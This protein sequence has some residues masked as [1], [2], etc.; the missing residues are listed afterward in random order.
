[1]HNFQIDQK[2]LSDLLRKMIAIES[3]NPGLSDQ[4]SG[5]S[6]IAEMLGDYMLTMGLEVE[7]Q[8]PEPGRKNVI[9]IWK[10]I[11]GGKSLLLNGHLDTVGTDGMTIPPFLPEVREGRIYGRGSMDMKSGVAAQIVSV[12]TLQDA[13]IRLKGDVLIT[14]VADEENLS[15]GT[16]ALVRDYR[17][18]AA[19]VTEPT[20]LDIVVA[21]KGFVWA[22]IEIAGKAAHGSRPEEGVD[23]IIKAGK[24]LVELDKLEHQILPLKSHP[25]LGRASLHASL[26]RGGTAI[27]VY[28]DNCIIDLERRTLPGED[29]QTAEKELKDVLKS[30][31]AQDPQFDGKVNIRFERSPMAVPVESE[32]VQTLSHSFRQRMNHPPKHAGIAFWTDAG[33]LNDAGIPT[34]VFGPGGKGLHAAV[35]YVEFDSVVKTAEILTDTLAGFCGIAD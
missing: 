33:L 7:Y 15:I 24:L 20:N 4:G 5:E 22:R 8:E 10:G 25:L 2:A 31:K 13:G 27:S 1:M 28:P 18:D 35:E 12:K 23:A 30:L 16:E 21:H 11:G 14:C 19:I 9:G 34:V 26:I 6:V 3:I 32:I 17:A 29:S